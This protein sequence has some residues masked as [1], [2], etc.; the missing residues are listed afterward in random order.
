MTDHSTI[1]H[2]FT[3]K[4]R[5][6]VERFVYN[7]S[8]GDFEGLRAAMNLTSLV[9]HANNIDI[10]WQEWKDA[11][12]TT[13]LHY[14]PCIN[15]IILNAIRKEDSVRQKLETSPNSVRLQQQLK[16]LPSEIKRLLRR[17]RKSVLIV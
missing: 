15:G 6:K 12:L 14:I 3:V 16:S 5:P 8:A 11:F 9:E 17:N 1:L 2:E 13:A 10:A 7:F 4:A